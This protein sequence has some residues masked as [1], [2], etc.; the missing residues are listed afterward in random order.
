VAKGKLAAAAGWVLERTFALVAAA[1]LTLALFLVLPLMQTIGAAGRD[2]LTLR[3]VDAA[4]LPPP[5]PPPP[6]P[7]IEEEEEEPPP[8]PRLQPT[9]APPLDLSQLELALNPGTGE[10]LFGDFTVDLMGQLGEGGGSE[11]LDRIFSLAELDRRPRVLFQRPPRYPPELLRAGRTGTVYVL[12]SVDTEG[13]VRN[14]RVQK[15]TDPAFEQPALDAV[16][17]WKFEPGTRGGEKVQF[18]MRIPITFNAG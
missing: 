13:R 11:E 2:D 17:Q 6:E 5:P 10:A 12:F 16:R 8:P 4:A 14:P 15:S 1:A 3:T 7:E 18:K 9:E